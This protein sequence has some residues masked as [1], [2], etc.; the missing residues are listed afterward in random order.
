MDS[1]SYTH[2]S[3]NSTEAFWK[4]LAAFTEIDWLVGPGNYEVGEH[5]GREARILKMQM[6]I[7]EF[8]ISRDDDECVLSYGVMK[9]PFVPV[10]NYQATVTV[11]PAYDGGEG[12]VVHFRSTFDLDE[13]PLEQVNQM[14]TAAYQMMG[15][16][17]DQSLA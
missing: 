3:P 16:Q 10:D 13:V 17:I 14:L 1:V 8:L 6:P 11:E 2:E 15:N 9:N 5:E 7:V 12:C 4:V